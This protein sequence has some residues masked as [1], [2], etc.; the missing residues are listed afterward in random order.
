[1]GVAEDAAPAFCGL[2]G[3]AHSHESIGSQQGDA[4]HLTSLVNAGAMNMMLQ[5]LWFSER[6]CSGLRSCVG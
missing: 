6:C 5:L 4:L 2:V 1:L 3:G